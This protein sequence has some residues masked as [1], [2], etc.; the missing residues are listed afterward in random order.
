[1]PSRFLTSV[2]APDSSAISSRCGTIVALA[3]LICAAPSARAAEPA[4]REVGQVVL[5]DVPE[6]PPALK[7]RMRQY[8]NVRGAGLADFDDSSASI[9]ISTRFGNTDQLHVIKQPGGARRQITFYDEPVRGGAFIPGCNG[10]RVLYMSDRGGSEYS[11]IY[12]L[13][14]DSGE[15]RMLTDGKSRHEALAIA[16]NGKR[17]AFAGTGRNGRDSDI[18]VAAAPDFAPRL[19]WEV[20]G[21]F[22][23]GDFSPDGSKLMVREY[24]S[25][26]LSYLHLLDTASGKSERFSPEGDKFAYGDGVF[27]SDGRYVF[28]TA[29]RDGQFSVLYR[30]ELSTGKDSPVTADLPWDVEGVAASP[31]GDDVAF[32]INEDGM[33]RLFLMKAGDLKRQPVTSLPMGVIGGLQF[34][35][36][37]KRL[38]ITLTTPTAPGDVYVMGLGDGALTR[39]TESE[40]GG[41]NAERFVTPQ[42]ISFPTFDQAGGKAREIPAYYF[43]PRGNGPFPV[44]V[45]IHG[46]PE[47]QY[48]PT[49]SSLM[50][51]WAADQGIAILAPNVRGS[52]GYGRDYHMLD[53]GFKREESVK[54]IGA[55]LDW[56]GKQPELDAARVGVYGGSYGGYMVLACLTHFPGRIKAGVDVVGIANFITFL[57]QTAE[58]RRDLRRPEY[59]DE[60]DPKMHEFL[61]KISPLN[62]ADKMDAALYVQHGANDPRVPAGE[63]EQ[64]VKKLRAKGRTVWYMLAKD[65][66]HGFAKKENRDLA[67]LTATMFFQQQLGGGDSARPRTPGA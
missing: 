56:I 63:A 23:P 38:G 10:R 52:T 22:Y 7:E 16:D 50:Q 25:E 3:L 55:L 2:V 35:H 9:L 48:R 14:L 18:Y 28:F 66:G 39:W 20:K 43:K 45:M 8:L 49:F 53:D 11:Q 54:D 33:S 24:I 47:A 67:N 1:M 41:L 5:E 37:G 46:G 40:I 13:D 4:R 30:R 61:T 57:E 26:K 32:T 44:I 36:D 29:D 62:N 34:S 65:E 27:S 21:A 17:I 15:S 12:L 60:R 64:I 51:N 42:R 19:L 59:G 58:Y 6:V 31:A